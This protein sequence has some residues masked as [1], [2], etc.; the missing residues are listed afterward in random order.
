VSKEGRERS[1]EV[2]RN[3]GGWGEKE[4]VVRMNVF[5]CNRKF[6]LIA[7]LYT[8]LWPL[9]CDNWCLMSII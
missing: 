5:C 4:H 9:L 1:R 7:V 2:G 8:I 6:V 3:R